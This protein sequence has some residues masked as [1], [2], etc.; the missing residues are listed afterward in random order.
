MPGT[1]ILP[2]NSSY[3]D[4]FCRSYHSVYRFLV[5]FKLIHLNVGTQPTLL[6]MCNI[7]L[8]LKVYNEVNEGK[9]KGEIHR[10]KSFKI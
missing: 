6:I 10:K 4:Y 9:Y 3:Y 1:H 8:M 5:K 2:I 7:F